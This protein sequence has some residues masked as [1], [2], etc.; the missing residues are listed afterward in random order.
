[1]IF[2]A[3]LSTRKAFD[4]P[5]TLKKFVESAKSK[6]VDEALLLLAQQHFPMRDLRDC[7]Y[8]VVRGIMG[9]GKTTNVW[10][11]INY[12]CEQ[13]PEKKYIPCLYDWK[14]W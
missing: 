6:E 11:A 14:S 8:C 3:R 13:V 1:V 4:L 5:L 7:A 10:R 12:V 9:C 2:L